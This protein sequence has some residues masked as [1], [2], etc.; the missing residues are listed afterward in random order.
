MNVNPF[1]VMRKALSM[2]PQQLQELDRVEAQARH[3]PRKP[4]APS[5]ALSSIELKP[6]SAS[7]RI[8]WA[9][10]HELRSGQWE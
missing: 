7:E 3:I 1:D 10:Q 4:A 2:T 8:D 9:A 5:M 6:L